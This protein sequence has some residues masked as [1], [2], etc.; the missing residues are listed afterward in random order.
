MLFDVVSEEIWKKFVLQLA[1]GRAREKVPAFAAILE[2]ENTTE[3][4]FLVD[5]YLAFEEGVVIFIIDDRCV[6]S[7]IGKFFRVLKSDILEVELASDILQL[8]KEGSAG[9]SDE[10][11]LFGFFLFE[12][13]GNEC[14]NE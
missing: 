5:F 13:L 12:I 4:A 10:D 3:L 9:G 14:A 11:W 6:A 8:P 7:A 2:T 1:V